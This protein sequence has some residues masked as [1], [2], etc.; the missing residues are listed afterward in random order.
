MNLDLYE[1][2]FCQPIFADMILDFL[3]LFGRQQICADTSVDFA[4][5]FGFARGAEGVFLADMPRS[6]R[7]FACRSDPRRATREYRSCCAPSVW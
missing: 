2:F 7:Q 6:D 4:G 3:E 5:L 1:L